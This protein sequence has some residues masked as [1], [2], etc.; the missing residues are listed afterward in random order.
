[1]VAGSIWPTETD[2]QHITKSIEKGNKVELQYSLQKHNPFWYLLTIGRLS[3]GARLDRMDGGLLID[4]VG[5]DRGH[6]GSC[7]DQGVGARE[8]AASNPVAIAV[9]NGRIGRRTYRI[10]LKNFPEIFG[11]KCLKCSKIEVIESPKEFHHL[12]TLP[13]D[14]RRCEPSWLKEGTPPCRFCTLSRAAFCSC[15]SVR[16][17]RHFQP[18]TVDT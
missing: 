13:V 9:D 15:A 18:S 14:R 4:R 12:L 7:R 11:P 16:A 17:W 2:R 5:P 6:L 8:A 10:H 3:S 1:M